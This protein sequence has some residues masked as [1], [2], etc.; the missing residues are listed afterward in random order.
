M[1]VSLYRKGSVGALSVGKCIKYFCKG[2]M[3]HNIDV[4]EKKMLASEVWVDKALL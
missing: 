1:T 4:K 2:M 3:R